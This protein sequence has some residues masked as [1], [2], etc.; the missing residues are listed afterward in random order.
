[1]IYSNTWYVANRGEEIVAFGAPHKLKYQGSLNFMTP[2]V[3]TR[4]RRVRRYIV[5]GQATT[6]GPCNVKQRVKSY[7]KPETSGKC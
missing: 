3:S 7:P 4:H 6:K 5:L 2:Y 1:M